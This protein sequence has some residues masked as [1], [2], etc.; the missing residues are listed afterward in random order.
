MGMENTS[1]AKL[2]MVFE[3]QQSNICL[4]TKLAAEVRKKALCIHQEQVQ[5][6][7]GAQSFT[8]EI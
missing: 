2:T 6:L 1:N 4:V 5:R 8:V 7:H 3:H